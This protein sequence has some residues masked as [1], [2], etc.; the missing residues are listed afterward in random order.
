VEKLRVAQSYVTTYEKE[1]DEIQVVYEED[2]A[3]MQK[4]KD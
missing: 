3:K 1:K 4:E 2:N